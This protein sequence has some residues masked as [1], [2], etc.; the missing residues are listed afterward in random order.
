MTYLQPSHQAPQ[1][2][3]VSPQAGQGKLVLCLH[4]LQGSLQLRRLQQ[5]QGEG[6]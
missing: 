6:G 1:L 3:V 5:V 2:C 4:L